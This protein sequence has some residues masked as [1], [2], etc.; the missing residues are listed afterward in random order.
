M[1]T[2]DTDFCQDVV[3][4][5][6]LDEGDRLGVLIGFKNVVWTLILDWLALFLEVEFGGVSNDDN[7]ETISNSCLMRSCR[8]NESIFF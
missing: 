4:R 1:E 8:G 2:D 3:V 5:V 7:M 6:S